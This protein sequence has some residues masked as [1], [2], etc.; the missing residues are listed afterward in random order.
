MR[1]TRVSASRRSRAVVG[2]E[3]GRRQR[4][5]LHPDDQPHPDVG[6]RRQRLQRPPQ[7][8]VLR[9]GDLRAGIGGEAGRKPRMAQHRRSG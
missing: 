2:G 3:E 9:R 1:A 8:E 6:G 5:G 7:R 4:A